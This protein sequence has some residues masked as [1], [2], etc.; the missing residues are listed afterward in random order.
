[1]KR[2]LCGHYLNFVDK[3]NAAPVRGQASGLS[4][5]QR[6]LTMAAPG[7]GAI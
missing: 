4:P 7:S 2:S 3:I 6:R 1:M 5:F